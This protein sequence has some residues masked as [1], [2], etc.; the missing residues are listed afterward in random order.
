MDHATWTEADES[1]L[2]QW[3]SE[4]AENDLEFRQTEAALALMSTAESFFAMQ[5]AHLLKKRKETLQRRTWK[6]RAWMTGGGSAL[7]V[8]LGY[9]VYQRDTYETGIGGSG[10]WT[11]E[12]GTKIFLDAGTR[13]RVSYNSAKRSILV[14]QGGAI[15]Q[16]GD[17]PRPFEV[18]TRDVMIRDIGT[19]FDVHV[20]IEET[21]VSVSEGMVEVASAHSPLEGGVRVSAGEQIVWSPGGKKPAPIRTPAGAFGSWREGRLIYRDKP[22]A[23]VVSDL[24]RYH[25][26]EIVI[27]DPSLGELKVRATL[28]PQDVSGAL[29]ALSQVLPLDV[30]ALPSQGFKFSKDRGRPM[31]R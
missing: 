2:Q 5:P 27:D 6:R 25:R 28:H 11:L 12:D 18:Q 22:L 20:R 30:K 17:D 4:S 23:Q 9:Y 26:G 3:R 14:K 8:L 29:D 19:T 21:E 7:L 31:P 15:F 1:A 13:L 24:Q 10:Q 16:V